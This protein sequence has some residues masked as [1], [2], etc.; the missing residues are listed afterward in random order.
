MIDYVT[1]FAGNEPTKGNLLHA[2]LHLFHNFFERISRCNPTD[3]FSTKR[4]L[5]PNNCKKKKRKGKKKWLAT[6]DP[7]PD[8]T[9]SPSRRFTD[10]PIRLC[11]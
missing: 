1:V 9:R 7:D 6:T 11:M 3:I 10:T 4:N 2:Q 5:F 8:P